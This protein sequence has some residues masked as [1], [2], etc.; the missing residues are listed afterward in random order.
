MPQDPQQ[1]AQPARPQQDVA[2]LLL[3]VASVVVVIA[4]LKAA[5]SII[6]PFFIAVFIA[7]ISFPLL[8]F[9]RSKRVPT[10]IA[11]L[12]TLIAVISVLVAFGLLVAGSITSFTAQAPKYQA[13]LEQL[14]GG[15]LVWLEGQGLDVTE[16]IT[17]LNLLDPSR[18]LNLVTGSLRA[19]TAVLSNLLLVFL[20][21]VFLL[22]E[23]AGF[24]AKFQKAFGSAAGSD[25]LVRIQ[26]EV[27]RYLAIK[28]SVSLATGGLV[29]LALTLIGVDF[30]L[31]WGTVAFLANY[32]PSL[33]SIIAAIPPTLLAIVQLGSGRAIAVAVVFIVI[34]LTLGNFL[35]PHLMG[36]RLGLS[37]LVV[38]LSLVFWGWIW[39]PVG[40]F[41]SVPLTM[42]I[43]I[44]LE[45]TREFRWVAV[46][47][48]AGP[49]EE[50]ATS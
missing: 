39:G 47:L 35:E 40:M 41:L 33:G 13:Q 26:T 19:V 31:L 48:D 32:I 28:T 38:F 44:A 24:P 5:A 14:F 4:G 29:A 46:L 21:I 22:L 23:A 3:V 27:Q 10:A 25:R 1:P 7:M 2:H 17:M 42:I 8:N 6:L 45:N 12:A 18:A 34:N 37:T 11:L 50:P 15:V 30:P 9:L 43:K 49:P 36:R 16:E 20:T